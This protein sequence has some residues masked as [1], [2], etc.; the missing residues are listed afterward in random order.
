MCKKDV[1]LNDPQWS[2]CYKAKP[3]LPL[4]GDMN[5]FTFSKIQFIHNELIQ[6]NKI[7]AIILNRVLLWIRKRDD[8]SKLNFSWFHA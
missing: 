8:S 4:G 1:A 5:D 7:C 6:S 3:N 2:L